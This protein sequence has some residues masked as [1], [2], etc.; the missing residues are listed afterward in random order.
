MP[1]FEVRTATVGPWP[2]NAYALVCPEQ[3][4][5]A[6][7]D[8][9]ADPERLL[10]LL[11]GT[12]PR[13]IILTHTHADHVG[14]LAQMRTRLGVPLLAHAGPHHHDLKLELDRALADGDELALGAG[15]LRVYAAPGHCADQLCLRDLGGTSVLVG[16]TIFAGGPGRTWSP[17][18]FQTTLRTLREVVLPWP[19]TTHCY[20]GHGPSFNLGAVRSQIVA[21]CERDH[22]ADFF[23]HAAW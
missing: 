6:L 17:E 4:V 12:Q 8:P 10:A 22:P 3:R 20:P 9:G 2:M 7:V 11:E 13:L 21:F 18:G 23:G 5:S 14:A 1:A 15:R 16:D 19:D